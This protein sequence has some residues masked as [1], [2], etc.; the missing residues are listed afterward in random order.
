MKTLGLVG[1]RGYVGQELAELVK[2]HG[3]LDVRL[4]VSQRDGRSPAD[5]ASEKLDAYALLLP[6]GASAP[7]VEAIAA[8]R[9]D[10]VIVDLS[11]D[12]RFDPQWVYGQPERRR[13]EIGG[14]TRIANPGCY[15][16]AVQLALAPIVP[17]LEGPPSAFGVSGYSGAG[18]TPSPRND[19]ENLKDQIVPYSLVGHVHERE[20]SAQL[21]TQVFFVPH[22]APFFRGITVTVSGALREVTSRD[23]LL[24]L[25]RDAYGNE[26]L[27]SLEEEPPSVRAIV[28]KHH[29]A[30]GGVSVSSNGRHVVVVATIDNLLGGAASQALRNLNLALGFEERRG[31]S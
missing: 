18:T 4:A 7:Y 26:P 24:S 16:T 10:A 14:A 2:R 5:V 28:G 3:G 12:H 19:P 21:G 17:L 15:A 1:V 22:V 9:A 6:N 23:A 30:I 31:L 11:A 8:A 29:V 20:V 27:V 13:A 25:Y